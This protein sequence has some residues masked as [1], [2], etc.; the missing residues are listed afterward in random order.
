[1]AKRAFGS[2]GGVQEPTAI[3]LVAMRGCCHR[4]HVTLGTILYVCNALFENSENAVLDSRQSCI[5][6]RALSSGGSG[7]ITEY[8]ELTLLVIYLS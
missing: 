2:R 3:H 6:L 4:R 5:D 7:N 8:H 1:M